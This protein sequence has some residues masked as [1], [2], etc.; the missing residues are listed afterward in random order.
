MSEH[1]EGKREAEDAEEEKKKC[2]IIEYEDKKRKAVERA[3]AQEIRIGEGLEREKCEAKEKEKR[4]WVEFLRKQKE[5][6]EKENADKKEAEEKFVT[7]MRR[8]LAE[9]CY[10]EKQI[11]VLV[12]GESAK[13]SKQRRAT[14][15]RCLSTNGALSVCKLQPPVYAK[16]HRDYL[17]VHAL[18]YFDIP[19]EHD[20]VSLQ[21]SISYQISR[22]SLCV[23]SD[24]FL[25]HIR[26]TPIKLSSCAKW[27]STRLSFCLSTRGGCGPGNFCLRRRRIGRSMLGPGNV[28]GAV[29]T[30][31]GSG[32]WSTGNDGQTSCAFYE[33]F[34]GASIW[35]PCLCLS[36]FVFTCWCHPR[37]TCSP[38]ATRISFKTEHRQMRTFAEKC[39]NT[40]K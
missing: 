30:R 3:K 1:A 9:F 12:D 29:V 36:L 22:L 15:P 10:T 2:V 14:S 26:A 6:E 21:N 32:S 25:V 16:V 4:D 23:L 33:L 17:S 40:D 27:M 24:H 18:I 38:S 19:Y 5:K 7:E 8:R 11:D 28:T 39:S 20:K 35:C 31:G 37:S 13:N 34:S